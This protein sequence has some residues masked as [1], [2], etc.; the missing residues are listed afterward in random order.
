[1][2]LNTRTQV[3]IDAL[4]AEF[5]RV[6][7]LLV[8]AA[9]AVP[10]RLR[11]EPF[12]GEWDLKNV[13]A[14]TV[15]WDYTNIEALPDF[16]A[17]RLPAF[18]SRFDADWAAIND[19]LVARYRLEDFD[20]LLASVRDSQRAFSDAMRALDADLDVVGFWGERRISL[21]GMMRAVSKDESEHVAQI[22]SFI[23]VA[24]S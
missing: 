13:L 11:D 17:G 14:H 1:V 18:F 20:A 6:R 19:D 5:D 3:E 2:A 23:E 8:E 12:V 7:A 22:R 15:G 16:R 24:H 9:S 21:R 4:I 10:P